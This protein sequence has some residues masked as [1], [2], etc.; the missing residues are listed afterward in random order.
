M[1]K[2]YTVSLQRRS[3]Y[4]MA[5]SGIKY[6]LEENAHAVEMYYSVGFEHFIYQ[7]KF[8]NQF[9]AG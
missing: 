8:L 9:S 3:F 2:C 4:H 5:G 6:Y 1:R 7:L